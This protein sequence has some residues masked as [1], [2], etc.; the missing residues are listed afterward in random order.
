M[1]NVIHI[2]GTYCVQGSR[3]CWRSWGNQGGDAE[4]APP[5]MAQEASQAGTHL[6][7][8]FKKKEALVREEC[9]RREEFLSKDLKIELLWR[10]QGPAGLSGS[11]SGGLAGD[12]AGWEF[13]LSALAAVHKL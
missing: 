12:V 13:S 8:V 3:F 2:F 1:Y 6:N 11:D 9:S 4:W 10:V 5:G 7:C